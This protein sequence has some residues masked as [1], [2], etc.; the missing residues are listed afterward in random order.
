M[1]I[2]KNLPKNKPLSKMKSKAEVLIDQL[3]DAAEAQ[4]SILEEETFMIGDVV[5]FSEEDQE[6]VGIIESDEKGV[7]QVRVHAIAG[8]QFE[9]TDKVFFRYADEL[10]YYREPQKIED[11]IDEPDNPEANPVEDETGGKEVGT[12]VTWQSQ[13]GQTIGKLKSE[14][15]DIEV[16]SE[17]DGVYI[18]TNVLVKQELKDITVIQGELSVKEQ[19]KRILAKMD[20]VSMQIDEKEN[21]GIIEGF[22]STYGNVDLG[23]D[24]ISKG[25]YTQTLKHKKGKVKLFFD[26]GWTVPDIAGIAFL[27]DSE[28]GLKLKGMMP[29]DATDVKNAFVKIKFLLENEEATGL[30]IG[31]DD[32]KSMMKADGTRELKE[33][34]LYEVSITPFPMDTHANIL[35]ARS[36]RIAYKAMQSKWQTLSD[37]PSGNQGE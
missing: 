22:A 29:L 14:E 19:T 12:F 25:A 3:R 2:L 37:A 32:I 23:G 11:E 17:E 9:P 16:Y 30:S 33:I 24:T 34:A 15:G 26:H 18:P 31:Y 36:K 27:E 13:A 6:Y 21:I 10:Q 7:F 35:S 1:I 4:E 28:N 8:T 20:N 5:T